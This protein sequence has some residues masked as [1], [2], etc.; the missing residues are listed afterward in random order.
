M[1]D[2]FIFN[3]LQDLIQ[4]Q[5][6]F[7]STPPEPSQADSYAEPSTSSFVEDEEDVSFVQNEWLA[8]LVRLS[9]NHLR[10]Y[11]EKSEHT[12]TFNQNIFR[13]YTGFENYEKFKM[14]L[15]ALVPGQNRQLITK[16]ASVTGGK[17][18]VTA[19]DWFDKSRSREY[20]AFEED[21]LEQFAEY[22][23]NYVHSMSVMDEFLLVMMRIRMGL[24]VEDLGFRFLISP[25]TVSNIVITWINYMY[26]QLTQIKIWPDR[27]TILKKLPKDFKKD[28]PNNV[29]IIDS[30]E[31]FT[32]TP[33]SLLR[34]SETYSKYKSTNTIKS[35]I[36][37]H[38]TGAIMY[39]SNT[40]TG[41]ISDKQ[42]VQRSGLIQVMKEKL[43]IGE[44]NRGDA[45]M[46]DKGFDIA[47]DLAE[48]GMSLNIPPYKRGQ[49]QFST[50]DVHQTRSIA[51]HRIHVERAI[52]KVKVFKIFAGRFPITLYGVAN[53]LW[54]VCCILSNFLPPILDPIEQSETTDLDS[55]HP[56]TI[57]PNL[58]DVDEPFLADFEVVVERN[59]EHEDSVDP[60]NELPSFQAGE[61]VYE[62]H[63]D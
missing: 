36:G 4:D 16:W 9:V 7:Q 40:Y 23:K 6:V 52:R 38:P 48:I 35:L 63:S 47:D 39:V 10:A 18:R 30:T 32:Q 44:L 54:T 61:D 59:E 3:E 28:Y 5:D 55:G 13:H 53:Q 26:C 17:K 51:A 11:E 29:L 8:D 2:S 50:E 42:L 62:F 1:N 58:M 19:S 46:A 21:D 45:I 24:S 31:I 33:S 43:A 34:Q 57:E 41:R 37:V 12:P 20:I 27:E 56:S 25:A 14:V 22:S 49:D 60:P 15:E